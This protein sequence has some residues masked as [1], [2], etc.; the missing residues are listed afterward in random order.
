M[1]QW[2]ENW[3]D[4]PFYHKLYFDRDEQE[5][6]L[7]ISNLMRYLQPPANSFMLDVACGKG[8]HS[9]TMAE[10]GNFVTGI[11]ISP[12][13]I[14]FAKQFEADNLEFFEH[15][16]RLTFRINYYHYVFNLF[17]SFGYFNSSRENDDA[18][19]TIAQSLRPNGILVFDYLNS[20]YVQEHLVP[21]QQKEIE[22]TIF[23]IRK[24]KTDLHFVKQIQIEDKALV[25]PL[26]F[27]EQVAAF[28]LE[29]FEKMLTKQGLSIHATFGDY[30]LNNFDK[31][32]SKRL[33]IIAQKLG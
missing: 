32:S 8:R 18:L 20:I 25:T 12:Q 14:V 31:N 22:G 5:A 27:Q 23:N 29:D 6:S 3:F 2:F 30:M 26:L 19:R 9:R 24:W 13:S 16:M 28:T 21:S 1:A 17:T 7:F 4:S 15:D 10:Y 33:I 11:D